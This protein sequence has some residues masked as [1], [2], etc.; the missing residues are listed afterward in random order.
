VNGLPG[1]AADRLP[2]GFTVRLDPQV[3]RAD[4]GGTLFG[5]SPSRLLYLRPKAQQLLSGDQLQ[6][7]DAASG[8]LARLLLD[9]GMA[10]PVVRPSAGGD[11]VAA[12]D[13]IPAAT[14]VTVVVPVR[15]RPAQLSRLLVALGP[16]L[17]VI[18]VDDGSGDGQTAA[19]ARAAGAHVVR[20]DVSRGPAAARN[21]GLA[22]V[23][24]SLVAFV[25]SDV[26]PCP[27]WLEWLL[28]HFADPAV[29]MLAPRVLGAPDPVDPGP[30]AARPQPLQA[31]GLQGRLERWVAAYEDCRSSLDLGPQA[32]LVTPRGR[33]S[34]VP[35]AAVLAR[36]AALGTGFDEHLQVGEDV[37]LVWRLGEAGWR[38]RYE[39]AA[40]VRHDHRIPVRDW[41]RR[42]AFYGTSAAP[43]AARHPGAVPPLAAA[44]WSAAVWSLLLL[45]RRWALAGAVGVTVVATARLARTLR[46]SQHPVRAA[47]ALAPRA[48]TNTGWQTASALTRHWWPLTVLACLVSRRARRVAL[49]AAVIEAVADRRRVTTALG[50]LSYGVA[51]R[52]DDLAYGSGLWWGAWRSRTLAPLL[53]AL[54]GRASS[55]PAPGEP[56][57]DG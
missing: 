31:R 33:V 51:H 54:S 45:Q 7:T 42:K 22:Q 8:L 14:D 46:R 2:T 35:S 50:P 52:L 27:G 40:Q 41:L 17:R 47:I 15:D 25:D 18:V 16:A 20:H 43:L 53:P 23:R 32:A 10:Q 6:V 34:Y 19:V 37:D 36:T 5:G 24:T 4:A 13:G 29:G 1:P 21:S 38:V 57:S 39:P 28:P 26:V 12:A 9:K 49:A 30:S 55:V 44:P 48:L 56:P 11:G 3:I